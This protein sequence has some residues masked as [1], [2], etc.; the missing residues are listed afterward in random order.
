MW[1]KVSM[2]K[3]SAKSQTASE[4]LKT[5]HK[6]WRLWQTCCFFVLLGG[7]KTWTCAQCR[8]HSVNS[9]AADCYWI[10]Q[11]IRW[12][13][14][15]IINKLFTG[16]SIINCDGALGSLLLGSQMDGENIC[17]SC[18]CFKGQILPF[19]SMLQDLPQYNYTDVRIE[20]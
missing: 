15:V 16:Q 5:I 17:Q 8:E 7:G 19:F 13:E 2:S 4:M 18:W 9:F 14:Y 1:K 11:N 6:T 12:L 10:V 3:S 20:S